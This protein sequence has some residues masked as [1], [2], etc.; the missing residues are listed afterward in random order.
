M[1]IMPFAK[2]NASI[3]VARDGKQRTINGSLNKC[4]LNVKYLE[5][6][7]QQPLRRRLCMFAP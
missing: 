7:L 6:V 4:V 1:K 5:M 3:V 2:T